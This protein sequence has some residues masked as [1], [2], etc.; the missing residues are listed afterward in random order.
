MPTTNPTIDGYAKRLTLARDDLEWIREHS[1][2]HIHL[3]GQVAERWD[4][5]LAELRQIREGLFFATHPR[6]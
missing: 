4:A 3:R 6:E 1:Q 2:P 5:V